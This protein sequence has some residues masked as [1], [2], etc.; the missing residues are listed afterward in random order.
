MKMKQ[1]MLMGVLSLAMLAT[2]TAG[3]VA[4][5]KSASADTFVSTADPTL[6]MTNGYSSIID[7][8][9]YCADGSVEYNCTASNGFGTRATFSNLGEES[10][11][12]I[13]DFS[14]EMTFEVP[15]N[16]TT[17]FSLQ[18]QENGTLGAG[19]GNGLH[20]FIRNEKGVLNDYASNKV[21]VIIYDQ[22]A[23]TSEGLA[24]HPFEV[25]DATTWEFDFDYVDG[26]GLVI[27]VAYG[28]QTWEACNY[29]IN[30]K[31]EE[32][33]AATSYKGWVNL[34]SYYFEAVES[35]LM[36]YKFNKIN[37][38][39]TMEWEKSM[40]EPKLAAY[41]TA[42]NTLT[43]TSSPEEVNAAADKNLFKEG[44]WADILKGVDIDGSLKSRLNAANATL[45]TFTADAD[46]ITID[47]AIDAFAASLDAYDADDVAKVADAHAKYEAIDFERMNTIADSFKTLLLAKWNGVKETDAFATFMGVEAEKWVAKK[48]AGIVDGDA[49]DL[50]TYKGLITLTT[51]WAAFLAD[52]DV[53]EVIGQDVVDG[54]TTRVE[55]VA[56]KANNSLFKDFWTEGD[57]WNAERVEGQGIY[58]SGAGEY[59]QTLGF[60]KKLTLGVNTEIQFNIIY[61][62]KTL[63]KNHL[64]IGFYP[65]ANTGTL[66][67]I[68]GVRVDFWFS[69]DVIEIKPVNGKT[70][71]AIYDSAYITVDDMGFYDMDDP[72]PD[73]GKYVV[74]LFEDN[75]KLAIS[76]NGYEMELS[77]I[78]PDLFDEGCYMTLSAYSVRG[79]DYNELLIKKAGG[80]NYA[81]Y[82]AGDNGGDNSGDNTGGDNSGED[83]G[84]G[85]GSGSG[86]GDEDFDY[87]YDYDYDEDNGNG[88]DNGN[89]S[90]VAGDNEEGGCVSGGCKGKMVV[91]GL[92]L[93]VTLPLVLMKILSKFK[94]KEED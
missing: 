45:A 9:S 88:N 76:V 24:Y 7:E 59:H 50:K 37:G 8:A 43:E 1:K 60:N 79:A 51:D 83:E 34:S 73:Q 69:G 65:E 91:G 72:D 85:G 74:K 61:A 32:Y 11:V 52:N 49:K 3:G 77:G 90:G 84:N 38:M 41:E 54:L 10:K 70:E 19:N 29:N 68:D 20:V 89:G 27:N 25:T 26:R 46:Y 2:A 55:A 71:S 67:D 28:E 64:H 66:G 22:A 31:L 86:D 62:M 48:E 30:A 40:L 57:T 14:C 18:T 15:N 36:T 93:S 16:M 92:V 13:L 87:D 17:V 44:I 5:S 6:Y 94:K 81:N 80:V 12:S 82:V 75:G 39:T 78:S 35:P 42:V 58:A 47:E 23:S 53:V 56:G 33:Y 4:I 63:G 21:W